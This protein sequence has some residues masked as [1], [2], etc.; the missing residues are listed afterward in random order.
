MIGRHHRLDMAAETAVWY[1]LVDL[2]LLTVDSG[3]PVAQEAGMRIV[4]GMGEHHPEQ[5]LAPLRH[6]QEREIQIYEQEVTR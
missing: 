3:D 5:L 2:V 4:T 6:E 1:S